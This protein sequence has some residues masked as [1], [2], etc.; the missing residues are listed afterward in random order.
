MR[1]HLTF[2]EDGMQ[3]P[4]TVS[5]AAIGM[6]YAANVSIAGQDVIGSLGAC[7]DKGVVLHPDVAGEE[8][9]VIEE[10]LGVPAMVGTVSF[11]SPLIGAGLVCSDNGAFAG[12][13]TTGP[14]LNRIEDALG[15]I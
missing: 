8:V 14:E 1:A 12:D 9:D 4:T 11:G 6:M 15:L 10:I 5:Q 3:L 13:E 7:N 2:E